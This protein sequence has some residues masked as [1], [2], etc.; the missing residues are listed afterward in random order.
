MWR[1]NKIDSLIGEQTSIKGEIEV[2]NGVRIDGKFEGT[3]R[4]EWVVVGK[5]AEVKGEINANEIII[6]GKVN[7]KII[8]KN[9]VEI[10]STGIFEGEL[11]TNKL[12]IVEGGFFEGKSSKFREKPSLVSVEK[13]VEE[14]R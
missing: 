5:K 6:W 7:G 3:I 4:A 8:A 14:V 11:F 12:A 13:V 2:K 9:L 1:R 10:Q